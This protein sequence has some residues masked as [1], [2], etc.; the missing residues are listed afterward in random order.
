VV[1]C[2]SWRAQ[3]LKTVRRAVVSLDDCGLVAAPLVY[4]S[5]S[6]W[7]HVDISWTT[8]PAATSRA[9]PSSTSAPTAALSA[10]T[11]SPTARDRR[12]PCPPVRCLLG[13]LTAGHPPSKTP[14]VMAVW[15]VFAARRQQRIGAVFRELLAVDTP[16][17]NWQPAV[18]P[19]A[20][21]RS[22]RSPRGGYRHRRPCRRTAA[23]CGSTVPSR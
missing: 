1:Y 16:T 23:R 15:R 12:R 18:V 17:V 21:A 6:A 2:V 13:V 14:A 10:T 19:C 5:A 11:T 8:P 22:Q 20:A 3:V 9:T 7:E 4:D